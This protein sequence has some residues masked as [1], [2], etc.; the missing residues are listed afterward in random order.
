MY[1]VHMVQHLLFT[2]GRGAAAAARHAGVAGPLGA[3]PGSRRFRV[4]RC[5]ARFLPAV[6]VFNVVLVLTHWPSIVERE[7]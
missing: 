7:R 3:A 5:C 6:I 4:V 1:S 2:H